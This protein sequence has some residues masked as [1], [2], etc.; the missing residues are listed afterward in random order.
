D[1]WLFL[2]ASFRNDWTSILDPQNRSFSYPSVDMSAVLSDKLEFIKNSQAISFLKV[3]VGYAGT[4]N[5][6]LDG[7]QR[8]GVM[9][10]I[11]GGTNNGGFTA[12]LP[13]YGAYA[14]YPTTIVGTGF[15]F[16]ST[17]GYSQSYIAV[18]NGLRPEH[19]QSF[20]TGFQLGLFRNRVNIEANYYNQISNNQTIPLQTS[21]AAGISTYLT[22]A[23]EINNSGVEVD[24]SL[25]PLF[26]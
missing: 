18:Q 6:S 10:F 23:G 17:P 13:T 12:A 24:L 8:L 1:G 16:G 4:G 11:A 14:I 7:Y 15:P 19:T 25:T 2:H 26:N 21:A 3:R 20:E 5:V 22:N 9:G